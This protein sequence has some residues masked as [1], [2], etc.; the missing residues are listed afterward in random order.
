MKKDLK[1]LSI[2]E[3]QKME[4]Q[5]KGFVGFF[6]GIGIVGLA[7]FLYLFLTT[8]KFNA[9]IVAIL[10]LIPV[11]QSQLKKIKVIQEE[12]GMRK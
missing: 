7:A 10:A 1:K 2:A 6:V 4:K 9:G 12:I 3:L 5:T 11:T 8:K